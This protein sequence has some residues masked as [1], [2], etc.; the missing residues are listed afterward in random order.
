[1]EYFFVL[2]LAVN[3]QLIGPPHQQPVSSLEE[4]L[5]LARIV[6]EQHPVPAKGTMQMSCVIKDSAEGA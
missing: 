5:D 1:M 3:G 2:F 4:C 6:G